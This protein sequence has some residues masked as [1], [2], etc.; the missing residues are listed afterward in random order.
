MRGF[1]IAQNTMIRETPEGWIV[2][3]QRGKGTYRVHK[4][5][6]K[7][8]CNCPDC[9][10]R[11][12]KCKHQWAVE[13]HIKQE[14][15]KNGN[16][17]ITKVKKVT[18]PQNWKAYNASQTNEIKLF[19]I[20]LKDL[21]E[22]I[23]EPDQ[24]M[25]RPRL[26]LRESF[27]CAIQKVY[28]QLSSRRAFTLYKNAEGRDQINKAPNFNAINKFLNRKD[29]TPMLHNLLT[30]SALPLKGVETTFSPDSSG[31]RTNQFNEYARHKYKISKVH[32]W[33]KAHILVG[34]KTNIIASAEITNEKGSDSPQFKPLVMEAHGSGFEIR[35][36]TADKAYSSRDNH[37]IARDVGAIAYIP[38]RSNASGR[39]RGSSTWAKAY[40]FFQLN[41]EEFMQHYHKRSNVETAFMMIKTKLGDKLKSKKWTAQKNELLGK[42]IAHNI[43]VLIHEMHELGIKPEFGISNR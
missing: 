13:Y 23:E 24:R 9:E 7:M 34:A 36:I 15:D 19:D 37:D 11:K 35:E 18:Y 27:F 33:V 29:I 20:L 39:S 5:G 38:F 28:S 6:G 2:P 40:H 32:Q 3:S 8:I 16:V 26:S 4:Q 22:S 25:G 30:V 12:V 1:E 43:I 17:T 14:T 10:L 42:F 31:F 21:V 41:R